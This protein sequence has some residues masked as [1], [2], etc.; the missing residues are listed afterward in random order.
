MPTIIGA[1]LAELYIHIWHAIILVLL[2]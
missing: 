1:L 2:I